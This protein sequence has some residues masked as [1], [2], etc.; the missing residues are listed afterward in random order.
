MAD[1]SERARV[2]RILTKVLDRGQWLRLLRGARPSAKGKKPGELIHG[3]DDVPPLLLTALTGFQHVSLVRIQLIY[4]AL[5][6]QAAGLPI[7][8]SVNMLSLAM[9]ALGMAAILQSLARGPVGSGFLCP[10]CHTGIFLEPSLAALKLGGLPL[11]FGMTIVAGIV[12]AALA[13]M[14]R[15]IRPLLPPRSAGWRF[16]WSEPVSR[17]SAAAMSSASA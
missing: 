14:L 4:P 17:R 8:A 9:I 12:Q 1:A 3:V 7:S 6:I 2:A 16:F 15:R 5:V 11:V 13:P 10:S